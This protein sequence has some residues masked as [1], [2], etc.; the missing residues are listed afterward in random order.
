M[1][2]T[3]DR[4]EEGVRSLVWGMFSLKDLLGNQPVRVGKQGHA[5]V[6][7]QR[8]GLAYRHKFGSCQLVNG[9]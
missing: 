2:K 7:I 6:C 5:R 1:G 8:A 9:F 3:E 4:S